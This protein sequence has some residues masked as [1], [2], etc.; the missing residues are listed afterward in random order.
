M[1][2][3]SIEEII[4]DI[5]KGKMVILMDDEDRENEGDIIVAAEAVTPEIVTFFAREACGLICLP[6][7]EERALQL[8]LPLMVDRNKSTHSTNFTV[9]IEAA[10]GT[11]TGIS[12]ADRARTVQAAVAKDAKPADIIQPG[13]IFPLVAKRGGVLA[14]AGHTEAGVDLARLGGFEP[15]AL[16]VEIM[17][18]DGTM[19]KR[20]ELEAFAE[21]HGIKIGTIAA[22]IEYRAMNDTT[23]DLIERKTINTVYGE[24]DLHVFHDRLDDA[25][26][27]ALSMGEF[28]AEDPTL[29]R[30][31]TL[32]TLR[33]LF[34]TV[35]PTTNQPGWSLSRSLQRIADEGRG[36]LVLVSQEEDRDQLL[37]QI[38]IFPELPKPVVRSVS[39]EGQIIFRVIGAGSQILS[40][41]GIGKMRLMGPPTRYNGLAGFH[42]EVVEFIEE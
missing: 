1:A 41:L 10:T 21:K 17:N 12:A 39:E 16:I 19:A 34:Q 33:D 35:L 7:T 27:Y 22:L 5:A 32:N 20:P 6:I 14:R 40:Q 18:E 3:N 8:D 31:Q 38:R 25:R 13:H 23:V 37:E 15:A 29:V 2:L 9:S 24:F 42:L 4:A 28:S 36:V 30:V 11:T 26:H